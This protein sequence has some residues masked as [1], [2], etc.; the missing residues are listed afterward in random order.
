MI[1]RLV[2]K[3]A[4]PFKSEDEICENEERA[5][6]IVEDIK[7]NDSEYEMIDLESIDQEIK[8]IIS[9][10]QIDESIS[11]E[12]IVDDSYGRIDVSSSI[13]QVILDLLNN[14]LSAFDDDSNRKEIKLQFMAN[15]YGLE[16]GCCDNAK[17]Q[18][19]AVEDKR[20]DTGLLVS[21]EI[22]KTIFDGKMNP[23][24]REYSR[25]D[26]YPADNSGKTCFYVAIP[27]S[28]KCLLKEGY[29]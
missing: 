26:I 27:Y 16:I 23:C 21:R 3:L 24:L 28:N 25:S 22:I 14:S 15:E 17:I 1:S 29:E 8:N 11:L 5:I 13:L 6:S 18:N 10:T 12:I 4:N 2:S 19:K 20:R 9:A 7:A